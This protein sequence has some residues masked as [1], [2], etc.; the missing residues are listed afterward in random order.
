[1]AKLTYDKAF[2]ELNKILDELQSDNVSI[3]KLAAKSKKANELLAFCKN[4]LRQIE[5]EVEQVSD[6]EE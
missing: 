5:E 4:K 2:A 6:E 1:M 3:D